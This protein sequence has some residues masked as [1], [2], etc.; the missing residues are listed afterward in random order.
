MNL[1]EEL[2]KIQEEENAAIDNNPANQN[3]NILIEAASNIPGSALQFGKDLINPILHPIETATSLKD[4]GV[5]I[6][7]LFTPGVQQKKK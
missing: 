2:Q 5:G 6:Y 4:L 7:Q 3:Q 1:L